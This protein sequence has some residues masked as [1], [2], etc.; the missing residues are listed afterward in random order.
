MQD[1]VPDV[2]LD[3]RGEY[4]PVPVTRTAK[5][6]KSMQSGQVLA[7]LGD[8]PG[9]QIDIPAWC[10]SNRHAFLGVQIESGYVICI[11][12]VGDV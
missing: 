2:T 8:D 1:I 3:C 7:I 10:S 12:R 5:Q 9:M 11:I 6:V 4:C